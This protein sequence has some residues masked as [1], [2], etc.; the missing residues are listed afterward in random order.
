MPPSKHEA[1]LLRMIAHFEAF[2]ASEPFIDGPDPERE[3]VVEK[4]RAHLVE[5]RRRLQRLQNKD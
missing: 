4:V 3:A 5:L 2:V 1:A